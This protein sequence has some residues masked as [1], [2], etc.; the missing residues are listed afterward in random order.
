MTDHMLLT[1]PVARIALLLVLA[2]LMAVLMVA[3]ATVG[4]R[5]QPMPSSRRLEGA[6]AASPARGQARHAYRLQVAAAAN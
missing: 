3:R 5:Q 2:A 1:S 6:V 4:P